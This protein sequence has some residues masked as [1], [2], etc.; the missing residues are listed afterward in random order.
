MVMR[1]WDQWDLFVELA[2]KKNIFQKIIL[3]NFLSVLVAGI[4]VFYFLFVL[5]VFLFVSSELSVLVI[6]RFLLS[7]MFLCSYWMCCEKRNL[8][9][10]FP[11]F[12][13]WFSGFLI[14]KKIKIITVNDNSNEIKWKIVNWIKLK[15][16]GLNWNGQNLEDW[17][18]LW[19]N[20]EGVTCN[21]AKKIIII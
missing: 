10:N 4:L 6:S 7:W 17:I 13:Y 11:N 20:L 21:L 16:R 8:I 9:F 18:E 5:A 14:K 19:P 15:D 2:L 12:L 1:C 3:W